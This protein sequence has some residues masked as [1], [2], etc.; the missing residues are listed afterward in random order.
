[1]PIAIVAPTIESHFLCRCKQR[2]K[3][4]PV[5]PPIRIAIGCVS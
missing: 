4:E 1:V 3:A 5:L 2:A